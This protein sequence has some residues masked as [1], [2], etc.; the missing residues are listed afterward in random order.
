MIKAEMISKYLLLNNLSLLLF[1]F[2]IRHFCDL[3]KGLLKVGWI[4]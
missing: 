4:K 2:F 1:N 3:W